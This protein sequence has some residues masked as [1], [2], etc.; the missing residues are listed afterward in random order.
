MENL[1]KFRNF[2]KS[3]FSTEDDDVFVV[4]MA[5]VGKLYK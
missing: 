2:M 1:E 4:Y 3:I 5:P